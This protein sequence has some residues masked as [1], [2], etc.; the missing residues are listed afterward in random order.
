MRLCHIISTP[1]F[2]SLICHPSHVGLCTIMPTPSCS[3]V[4]NAGRVCC[5]SSCC[6]REPFKELTSHR[7]FTCT[8]K[9]G[10]CTTIVINDTVMERASP[11]PR[12]TDRPRRMRQTVPRRRSTLQLGPRQPRYSRATIRAKPTEP[13]EQDA[14]RHHTGHHH[15][16]PAQTNPHTTGASELYLYLP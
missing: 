12:R 16:T 4:H 8:T 13:H 2:L 1:S 9:Q 3:R 10:R 6:G 15:G 7:L 14:P 11:P 5:A